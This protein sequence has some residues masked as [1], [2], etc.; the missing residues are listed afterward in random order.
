MGILNKYWN[1]V[2]IGLMVI[3]GY[4]LYY[5]NMRRVELGFWEDGLWIFLNNFAYVVFFGLITGF[6]LG[7]LLNRKKK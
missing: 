4:A 2:L 1:W 5:T 7:N 3:S 6:V